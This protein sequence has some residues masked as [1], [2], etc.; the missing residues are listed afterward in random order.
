MLS[1]KKLLAI[2]LVIIPLFSMGIS[3]P[4][5]AKFVENENVEEKASEEKDYNPP[6]ILESTCVGI[7][8]KVLSDSEEELP[9]G[10]T[11][12]VQ[13][14]LIEITS[15]KDKGKE[16]ISLNVVP[17]NPAYKIVGEVGKKY[18]IAKIENVEDGNEEYYLLDYYRQNYVFSLMAIFSLIVILIGGFKGVRTMISL[19]LI[20]LFV[21]YL[22]IP[23]IERGI[24]PLLS[25]V[26]VSFLATGVTM[27]LVTGLNKKS[28][29]A[30]LGTVIGVTIS[31]LIA[32]FVIKFAPLSGMSSSEAMILWG[33]RHYQIDFRGL[34]AAG[35]IV[36]CL[37]AVMD[38]AISIA[39]SIL[40]IKT[41]NPK[42]TVKKLFQSGMNIGKDIIGTM[43]N[44]LVLA[45]TGMA[46][47]LLILINNESNPAKFL[48]I[49]LVVS[50]VTAAIAG[51][52]GLIISVPVTAIIMSV[53]I[54]KKKAKG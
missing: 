39:S 9:T 46:L 2:V 35:M 52:I 48:N 21:A 5:E 47:P 41:A 53:L 44:T 33:N 51:S 24:N 19:V 31:G 34:L 30:T 12:R 1:A 14:V 17:D 36:S 7:V 43:T 18:L 10:N 45:Y 15:G 16:R 8:T 23:S 13:Q 22:L 28:I 49:E 25:A 4:K 20:I 50:E 11:Q 38:V 54:S 32:T 29:A 37:G 26:F 3:L 27:L 6:E 40:E 42:Y